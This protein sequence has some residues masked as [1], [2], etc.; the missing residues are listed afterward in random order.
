M[1]SSSN[2]NIKKNNNLVKI[3][4]IVSLIIYAILC[5]F[6]YLH[7]TAFVPGEKFESDLPYHISMALDGWGYSIT[8]WVYRIFSFLPASNMLISAF[9]VLATLASVL[10]TYKYLDSSEENKWLVYLL[11]FSTSFA[12]PF[13]ISAIHYQRYI[14]YQSGSIWHNSTYIVM[15]PL[16]L[17]AFL[18]YLYIA[19]R[20]GKNKVTGKVILFTVFLLLSTATK[21]SFIFVFAPAAFIFLIF[22]MLVGTSVKKVLPMALTVIPSALVIMWQ[23]VVLFGEDTGN[24]ISIDFGYT[25]FLRAEKPYF[26]MILSALFPVI[27]FLFN[28][29]P[30]IADTIK[31]FKKKDTTIKHREFLLSWTMWIFG[32]AELLFLKEDGP[33]IKDANFAWGYDFCLFILFL[34]SGKYFVKNLKEPDFLKGKKILK[35]AY[36]IILGAILAYHTYCGIYFFIQLTKGATYFMQLLI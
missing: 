10:I 27:I 19:D 35:I 32:A 28:I 13:F 26:T 11:T 25:V 3:I 14:G 31:D 15:K 4:G 16:S 21:T 5:F 33:R 1:I 12:M 29:V 20:Y 9:L 34:I 36:G 2:G 6:L 17:V 23:E 8:A 7:Q 24:S 18:L 30:V 22:D